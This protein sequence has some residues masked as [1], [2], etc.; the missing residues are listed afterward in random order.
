[1][2]ALG[3]RG[4]ARVVE[5]GANRGFPVACN[6]GAAAGDGEIIVLL[7]NDVEPR[8]DF[9]ERLVAPLRDDPRV[10][11]VA[12]LLVQPGELTI[13]SM[14]LVADRTLAG[15][16]RLRGRPVGH[17]TSPLPVLAGPSAAQELIAAR[18]G[19]T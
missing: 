12:A 13:D 14:G 5:I 10:G 1:M 9:L 16:P 11:S 4:A 18:L 7:N 17:A 2:S 15:F 19:K 3:R 8:P 6:R